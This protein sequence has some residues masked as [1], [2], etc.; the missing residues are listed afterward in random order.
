MNAAVRSTL[1]L[2]AVLTGMTA[3]ADETR[4]ELAGEGLGQFPF[5]HYVRNFNPNET[6]Q[7]AL[8]PTRFPSWVGSNCNLY[9]V[10]ARSEDGWVI[11]DSLI[12]VRPGGAQAIAI[13]AKDVQSNTFTVATAGALNS[14][15][16]A[17]LGVG[18]DVVLD[19]NTNG[20]LDSGDLIDGRGD[21]PGFYA[22]HDTTQAG[23]L[24][25]TEIDYS[26]GGFLTQRAYYP[27]AIATMG[28]LPLVVISHGWTH[29]YTWYGHI[30][31][32]LASY[33]YV[34]ISH[35]NDV[36]SGNATATLTASTTTLTNIDYFLGELDTIGS[37]AL[38]G[39]IDSHRIALIGHSTGAEGVVRA[40]TRL[41]TNDF[42]PATFSAKDVLLVTSMAPVSFHP[43]ATVD[44][45]DVN[46]FVLLG[47]ADADTQ[48]APVSNWMQPLSIFERARGNRQLIYM[49]GVGHEW[50]HTAD[51]PPLAVGPRLIGR[52]NT[53]TIL[54]G[55]YLPVMEL[56]LK[57]NLAGRDFFT[58]NYQDY[59]PQGISADVIIANEYRDAESTALTVIDDYQ[60]QNSTTTSSSGGLITFDVDNL[61]EVL[62]EDLDNSLDW[63]GSQPSNGMARARFAGDDPRCVV[64]DWNTTSAFYELEIPAAAGG[65]ATGFLSF[66]AAQGTRHPETL[67]HNAAMSFSV[68]LRDASNGTGSL[69]FGGYGSLTK[70]YNRS[71]YG[72]VAGWAS[73][74][75]TIRI[76]LTDFVNNGSGL[77]VSALAAVRF[78]MGST[79]GATRGRIG[80]DDVEIVQ[81]FQP[82]TLS[83]E[84]TQ[85]GGTTTLRWPP[86]V[87]ALTYNVYRGTIPLNGLAARGAGVAAYDHACFE[88]ADSSGDGQRE[89]HDGDAISPGNFG[90]YYL[91]ATVDS[92]GED[93]PGL[94]SIDLDPGSTGVQPARPNS[95]P[96][97]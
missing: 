13:G 87:G 41:R 22:V 77:D 79:F 67:A 10:A 33:G 63:T 60:S 27:S 92:S 17:G 71:G 72:A 24:A 32:H 83:L 80:L 76:R 61:D 56:Y 75:S 29:D 8:D 64:F 31:Q 97:P 66:R 57:D 46:Y 34:V 15:A 28:R 74:F 70:L 54:R 94:A 69:D 68:E 48:N 53:H 23:P 88:S 9:V 12:D 49:H 90:F 39:H 47:A 36:G 93:P 30:G 2:L 7:V 14:D 25:V 78:K 52:V 58:R 95:M 1:C 59:H 38:D 42:I 84:L 45:L 89:T 96:C 26:G 6:I 40:Y 73:E 44:P 50:L 18:Y 81:S 37:G 91:V 20:I 16:G 43:V 85:L 3:H 62:M 4:T 65:V 11:D 19:C 5:F 86:T 21:E 55:Y 35:T 82:T 51:T